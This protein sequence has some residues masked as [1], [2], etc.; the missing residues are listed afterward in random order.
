MILY[1]NDNGSSKSIMRN[2]FEIH[3]CHHSDNKNRFDYLKNKFSG[4]DY[5][6]E[7]SFHPT[8]L[9]KLGSAFSFGD[10]YWWN[11]VTKKLYRKFHLVNLFYVSNG[12]VSKLESIFNFIFNHNTFE[13][14]TSIGQLSL[15]LKHDQSIR[16][17]LNSKYNYALIIE[18]DAIISGDTLGQLNLLVGEIND[19][20]LAKFPFFLDVGEGAKMRLSM[21]PFMNKLFFQ[22]VYKIRIR[23]CRTTCAY[24]INRDFAKKW[25]SEFKNSTFPSNFI[26]S[27]FLMSGFLEHF[28]INVLWTYPSYISHGSE[29]GSWIS[30]FVSNDK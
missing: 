28:D 9:E 4:Y 17:F 29:N 19:L 21:F 18:D 10:I 13:K 12:F 23:A 3:I 15:V 26:G 14:Q 1:C 16:N 30:N 24:I 25:V 27:D 20:H 7:T 22:N 11:L 8:Q 6:F 2:N 5:Y